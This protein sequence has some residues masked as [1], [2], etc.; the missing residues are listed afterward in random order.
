VL[1]LITGNLPAGQNIPVTAV[2]SGDSQYPGSTS[3]AVPVTVTAT[4]SPT[5]L[6]ASPTS[7]PEGS[8]VTLSVVVTNTGITILAD[9]TVDLYDGTTLIDS[10]SLANGQAQFMPSS[11]SKGTHALTAVYA[12]SGHFDP[13]LSQAVTVEIT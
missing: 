1:S 13:S 10:Q 4:P 6:S 8:P 3:Q 2:Y 7:A 5:E 11:L 9:G 12:G